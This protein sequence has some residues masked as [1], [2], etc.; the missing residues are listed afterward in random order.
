MRILLDSNIIIPLEDSSRTLGE[1]FSE[2]ARL[3]A[4]NSHQLLAHP[5][6]LDDIRRDRDD[7]RREI[8]LSR[9]R[10]Y[11]QLENPPMPNHEELDRL[12]LTQA[13]DNDRVDNII[14]YAVYKDAVNILVT[15]DK[16]LHR[17]AVRLGLVDR[18]YYIQQAT[19]SLRRLH[20]R[21]Q[22]VLPN[23]E[24]LPL[25]QLDL[26]SPF[27]DSLR[28]GYSG[29]DTWFRG[30]SRNGRKAWTHRDNNGHPA[31]IAIFKEEN[32][33]TVTVDGKKIVG[34]VLKIS[35]FKVGE[36]IRGKKIGELLLKAAFRYASNNGFEHIYLTMRPG[37]QPY[38][39][40]LCIDFGFYPFGEAS[41]DGE[42][43]SVYVKD[44]P[45]NPPVEN[46]LSGL[47]YHK[48]FF[49]HFKSSTSSAKYV[50]PI[51]PQYHAM[52]FPDNQRQPELFSYSAAGNAIKQ[53]YLSNARINAI[54]SGDILLFYRSHDLR[55]ITSVGIVESSHKSQDAD[56]IL[57]LVSKRTV[58]SY[59][60][61]KEMSEKPTKIILFRLAAHFQR[62][63]TYEWLLDEE[64]VHGPIQT[65]REISD[66]SFRKIIRQGELRN[67]FYAD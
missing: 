58:Y 1:S 38:L 41:V 39:E 40:R 3:S 57:Q 21:I 42:S 30:A 33:P 6:S 64:V 37:E 48:R 12:G 67:C 10:K 52:L 22:V 13:D 63:I 65:I 24:E 50:V 62:D 54:K 23:I 25:H 18:V 28:A 11:P 34:K 53:A 55:A 59:E 35:T 9:I 56:K 47:E 44:Q 36:D 66:E 26:S 16:E 7:E 2:L 46:E 29:F 49:P 4:E 27:F 43:D 32:G 20:A 31:A 61:I 14:L 19:E 60:D 51:R 17:K 8:S 15:E 45:V 5:A